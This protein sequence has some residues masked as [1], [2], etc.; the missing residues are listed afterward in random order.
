MSIYAEKVR[1]A[2]REIIQEA[3]DR[4]HG[5]KFSAARELGLHRNALGREMHSCDMLPDAEPVIPSR[6]S[7]R[8]SEIVRESNGDFNLAKLEVY[9]D[10]KL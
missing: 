8:L 9:G 4:N 3:L 10:P 6:E 1:A 7:F 2:K 5:N